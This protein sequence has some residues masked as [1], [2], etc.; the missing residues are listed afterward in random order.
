M[1]GS[2]IPAGQNCW[3]AATTLLSLPGCCLD[4]A[5]M[6]PYCHC[7]ATSENPW[8]K[9]PDTKIFRWV[10]FFFCFC[11]WGFSEITGTQLIYIPLWWVPPTTTGILPPGMV[12]TV[13]AGYDCGRP[14]LALLIFLE[15]LH[16]K[17]TNSLMRFKLFAKTVEQLSS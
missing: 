5:W 2:R 17:L 7:F 4:V 6:L 12:K 3:E 16:Y 13:G 14:G 10:P 9:N 11:C 1:V 15:I 8:V